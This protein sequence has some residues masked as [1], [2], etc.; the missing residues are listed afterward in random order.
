MRV[1][2]LIILIFFVVPRLILGGFFCAI[3]QEQSHIQFK[4]MHIR[5]NGVSGEF[6]SYQGQV[7]W[8]DVVPS[9]S[10]IEGTIDVNSLYTKSKMR[11]RYL[12]SKYFFHSVQ[13]P[14]I[15]FKS[16][17]VKKEKGRVFI[18]GNL[19]MKGITKEIVIPVEVKKLPNDIVYFKSTV[20]IN[21]H[22]FLVSHYKRLIDPIIHVDLEIFCVKKSEEK[23]KDIEIGGDI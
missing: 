22:D 14:T 9:R 8:D 16:M 15:S 13:F 19:M 21:R 7:L 5:D 4:A 12:K 18:I 11:D 3:D 2:T 23:E 6:L 1:L 20:D 17:V 10:V